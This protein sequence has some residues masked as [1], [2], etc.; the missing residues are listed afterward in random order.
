VEKH[1]RRFGRIWRRRRQKIA[2]KWETD[3]K[4][5]PKYFGYGIAPRKEREEEHPGS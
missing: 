2:E 5:L 3:W 4:N 1:W